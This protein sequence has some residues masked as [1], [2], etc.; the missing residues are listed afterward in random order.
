MKQPSI[1]RW[2]SEDAK[3]RFHALQQ[4]IWEDRGFPPPEPLDVA[5]WAGTTRLYRWRGAGVPVVL[6]HGMGGTGLTWGPYV[7]CLADHELYAIDTIGDVGR[8]E[9]TALIADAEDLARWLDETLAG[10]GIERAHLVGT[11]YGGYLALNLAAR[12]PQRVGSITLIDAGGLSPFRLVRFMLW[13]L[14]NLLGS[15]A[16]GPIRRAMARTRPLLEDP[17]IMKLA[18]LGQMNHPFGMPP[19][20]EL[21]HNE[22]R[23]ITAPT[24]VVI[25]GRSAPF[26]PKLAAQRAALIPNAVVD[27]VVGAGHEVMRTHVDRCVAHVLRHC[28]IGGERP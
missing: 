8:S 20:I 15:K 14:P 21:S 18:L 1:S 2:K 24:T 23:T 5:T 19:P 9:Q 13:G 10:A 26:E 4:V 28:K 22:L 11:S 17:R 27:L 25:A 7:E 12:A 16:P 3:Q 6:L